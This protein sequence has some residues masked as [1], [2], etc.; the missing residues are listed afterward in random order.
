M[1]FYTVLRKL[2][3]LVAVV[4]V[5]GGL[6]QSMAYADESVIRLSAAQI[7]SLGID[8]HQGS[9]A[10]STRQGGFPGLVVLP[11]DQMRLL[12]AP[13]PALVEQ[14]YG[15][16]GLAVKKGQWLFRLSVPQALE[17]R[18][19]QE[20]AAAANVLAQQSLKRD[21]V[22]FA[23][24]IIA[25]S[26]VQATRMAAVQ[27][28]SRLT[29]RQETIKS[30]GLVDLGGGLFEVRATLDGFILEQRV[31]VGQRVEA[32]ELLGKIGRLNVL[33]IDFHVPAT[34]AGNVKVGQKI[35]IPIKQ[36][37]GKIV[38]VGRAVDASQSVLLR[39]KVDQGAEQLAPGQSVEVGLA[40]EQNPGENQGIRQGIRLPA[41]ALVRHQ[42]GHFVFVQ[43]ANEGQQIQF[44]PQAV[45]LVSQNGEEVLV[46][47][48]GNP[49]VALDKA[50]VVT[51]GTSGLKAIWT[52]VGRE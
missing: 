35:E 32:V 19:D 51:R 26:R 6:S 49:L 16:P 44:Q 11:H 48:L 40:G 8:V 27:A 52:G 4:F 21:E 28:S 24:G 5:L 42:G 2:S 17:L 3:L 20:Q 25:E 13:L 15:A 34:V 45:E 10:T 29:E 30:S 38:A 46:K 7:K 39:A 43:T 9:V 50:T 47:A 31:Q 12:S 22:L 41:A 33:W 18:R 36:L 14:I 1:V 23:E 37:Q